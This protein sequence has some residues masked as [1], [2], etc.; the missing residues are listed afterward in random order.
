MASNQ[1]NHRDDSP[2]QSIPLQDL[3]RP[4]DFRDGD[5]DEEWRTIRR[6]VSGR[7]RALL[8]GNRQ[9]FNGRVRTS[10][11]YER[12]GEEVDGNTTSL[13]PHVTT[14]RSA[15]QPTAF[16]EEGEL[17]PVNAGEFQAAMGSVGLTFDRFSPAR[18][19]I[20]KSPPSSGNLHLGKIS[21][22]E[23]VSPFS[24]TED[25]S[26]Q[27]NDG[28]FPSVN[29]DRTPLTDPRYL[30]PISGSPK[31]PLSP[32]NKMDRHSTNRSTPG[33][34]LGDDL[35]LENGLQVPGA[36][37]MHRRSTNSTRSLS[38]SLSTSANPISTAGSMLRKMSQRVVNLSNEP[39]VVEQTRQKPPPKTSR[40]DAP[41]SF[42]A[43]TEYAHDEP[44]RTP[45]PIEKA[46]PL[47][48]VGKSQEQW[49]RDP[50]PLKGNSLGIF[51]PNNPFRLWLC[52]I[53]VHPVTE[54][55]ILILIV[56]QTIVLAVDAGPTAT[57]YDFS[58]ARTIGK[59]DK[60]L[61]VL[62]SIYS[63]EIIARIIVSGFIKNADEYS[64]LNHSLSLKKAV[65]EQVKSFFSAEQEQQSAKKLVNFAD[66]QVSIIRSFTI[67]Q[68]QPN[69]PGHS[70]QQQRV[71]LARR[72]FLRHGFNRL[73]FL[74]VI[75]FWIAFVIRYLGVSHDKHIFVFQMLSCLRILRLLG[76]TNGTSVIL[77]SLKKAAPLL[78]NVA[79]LIGFFWLLFA[80]IATQSFKASFRRTC[81]WYGDAIVE[82]PNYQ[83]YTFT[84][85]ESNSGNIYISN[86]APG[87]VQF[88]GGHLDSVTRNPMPWIT[89]TNTSSNTGTI[90]NGTLNHKGYLCPQY[91]LCVQD[92]NPYNGT[93]SFDNIFQSLELVFVIMS[94]NTF[95][96]LLYYTTNTDFLISALF[97]AFGTV[98]LTL[99]LMNLL[100][101]VITS[102]FQVIREESK[103]SAFTADDQS[104]L[105][106]DYEKPKRKTTLKRAYER[107]RWLWIMIIVYGLVVQS[108][109]TSHLSSTMANFIDGS[110][111]CVTLI[112]LAETFLR[113]VSD[114]RNF[115]KS[116]YNW[117]DLSIA[118]ITAI[119]QLPP[120]R[121]SGQPYAWLTFFQII[122]I[123]RVVLAVPITRDLIKIVLKNVTGLLNLIVFVFL[124]TFLVA[125]FAVQIFRGEIP[126]YDTEGN[127]IRI[128][129][130]NIYNAF[131]G[132]YQVFS[133]E[134]WTVLMYT[135][136]SQE[137]GS[138][139]AWIG[140][141][142]FVL[143]FILANFIILNMFIAVIQENFDVSE[144]DKRLH[145][146]KAFLQ[147]KELVGSTHGNLS[148]ATIFKFGRDQNRYR[149][150]IDSGPATMDMFKDSFVQDFLD[151]QMGS[152]DDDAALD[153]EGNAGV[154][155][156][157]VHTGVLS[158]IWERITRIVRAE[159]NP[160][161]SPLK[162]SRAY[163]ELDP[164][165][166]AEELGKATEERKLAQRR[167]LQD[168]PNYN[169]SLFI[170][171]PHSRIRK[172]CQQI[173]GPGRGGARFEG[174][175]PVKWQWY[176]FSFLIY[177]SV[178]AMVL[179]ACIANPLYQRA[180]SNKHGKSVRNWFVW[181]DMGFAAIFSVESTIKIIADGFFWTPNAYFRSS[182]GIIDGI[183]LVTLWI[184]V[185]TS[186]SAHGNISRAVG[187]FKALR[188]LRLL[189]VSDSARET[190]HAIIIIGGW[191]VLSAAFVSLSLL[192]PF[193]LYGLNLFNGQLKICNDY[194]NAELFL[195]LSECT[196]EYT[197][198]PF[199][200]NWNVIAPR[201]VANPYYDFDNFGDSLFILFQIVSQEGWIDV[202]WSAMEAMGT[203]LQPIPYA[204]VGNSV[205]FIVF[206]LLGAVFV[207][208]L[209]VSVF[210]RN[211][212]EQTGVAFL[213]AEQRS[214]LELRKL[215]R[216]ISPSKRPSNKPNQKW[217][218][219]CYR[220]A[221]KKHGKWQRT[222]TTVLIL[223]LI[224]LVLEFYPNVQWWDITREY[225]FVAFTVLYVANIVIR[226]VGLTW[227]RFRRSSWD[228]YSILVVGANIVLTVLDFVKGIG[229]DTTYGQLHKLILV[230][231]VL[232]LIPRNN[233]LDQLFKTAA[234]SLTSIG[235]LLATWF[236]LFL[237]YAIA[238]TQTLGL[239]R[240]GSQET[241]NLN[242]RSV[243]KALILLFRMSE[244]E[245]WN[246]IMEDYAK[247][248]VAPLC[249]DTGEFFSSDCGSA[250]W[251]RVLFISWNIV[252]MYIFVSMFVSLIFESFSYVYQ[253]SSGLEVVS[254][255]EIRRFKEAWATFDPQGTGYISKEAFP[256]LLGELSGI[257]EMRIYDGD[258]TIQ[259]LLDHCRVN[260]INTRADNNRVANGT[261]SPPGVVAGIDLAKLNARLRTIDVGEVRR[262]RE[263]LELFSQEVY[264]SETER[265][266]PF[267]STLMI[268]AHYNVITDRNSLRLEEFLRR[269]YRL[270]R[271]REQVQRNVVIGFFDMLYWSRMLNQRRE[272]RH[273]ARM[274]TV[275]QFAIPEI[276]VD[277][278]EEGLSPLLDTFS[279][280][281]LPSG[282][283]SPKSS[284][285]R[286]QSSRSRANSNLST[287]PPSPGAS[288]IR[289]RSESFNSFRSRADSFDPSP[290][291]SARRPSFQDANIP[292]ISV[293][294][295]DATGH[296]DMWTETG[297]HH[298]RQNS[299]SEQ[300]AAE[301]MPPRNFD[302]LQVF[303]DS[304]WGES[305]RRSFTTR[306]GTSRRSPGNSDRT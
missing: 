129:F 160:F 200:Q 220:I 274:V 288:G 257:F 247:Y 75:S 90:T 103:T 279:T 189:N 70:R 5:G 55:I 209:F 232:L 204:S 284:P 166:L 46:T 194:Q 267:S 28:Y 249:N 137:Y 296:P 44:L 127:I 85:N 25:L 36:N 102:S 101:A 269:R 105:P 224:L 271:V 53:L 89:I 215:L 14:P 34:R 73:D 149:D 107:T 124:M 181:T 216:Q 56:I 292:T 130:G 206:N 170:F 211:F 270:Q 236:V 275:P 167:Y 197:S 227:R 243:P 263:I 196:G 111:T 78:A 87:N 29:E 283:I 35:S 256:R 64:T 234:A 91:S 163:E 16:F 244:G 19:S 221:V 24:T 287:G 112:L 11:R 212:T 233:Q 185:A 158:T 252:S 125:I 192:I 142:F 179:L 132:M 191:K 80:I 68:G 164:R 162:F 151:E 153:G 255:E 48:H 8:G 76:L 173:V 136:T 6:Q 114:W 272:L 242:F 178:V 116:T 203:G 38:R 69:Q 92:T 276:Y 228:L 190:F 47:I 222:I 30:Q 297:R 238:L 13:R 39:E 266:I 281:N 59:V 20:S 12:V 133:S 122:R 289:H 96:D 146:V 15:H 83:N 217:K 62:F 240:F 100:V 4:P 117:V 86:V 183:V 95:T 261:D 301:R 41:P 154:N 294:D 264:L 195:N 1:H 66:P 157:Q 57:Y 18:Q 88:C 218:T 239:T 31:S 230:S 144:D 126:Q 61:L 235:N 298:Q 248:T 139:T 119:T 152:L 67:I 33:S 51:S 171:K 147:Q 82:L 165:A 286:A 21:E 273:S 302:A 32:G 259:S 155:I 145:Q 3:P 99:W 295:P 156:P 106:E 303:D 150:P 84:Y 193:A 285:A 27:D 134:N 138:H 241:G 121:N 201:V 65:I 265:G 174:V 26:L 253:R 9:S 226:I 37:S 187:A 93:V 131:I 115:H 7:A 180:Y 74:A 229:T 161:Y 214:W 207:L 277:N 71:R 305:I 141:T 52:E 168:H 208:T 291:L 268:L 186:L 280:N 49:L 60:T 304:A 184:N 188:A 219:W 77:R 98:F 50:N 223:H 22:D 278:Q 17:S 202:M 135:V 177:A 123:Y 23:G 182:W 299:R 282:T 79:F 43:M 262:K 306:R 143:W 258:H 251:A 293:N 254:R 113:F 231:I 198:T 210:M 104:Q 148:L 94:S 72:A 246:Q 175:D 45:R 172:W 213:T 110:E 237:V 120:I 225:I 42:P 54:P 250:A 10:G 245:G 290:T 97:F 199:S 260:H 108:L 2:P 81:A 300:A 128:T 118:V 169:K 205:F 58:P 63:L 109:R 40:L 140:A 176:L 159:P